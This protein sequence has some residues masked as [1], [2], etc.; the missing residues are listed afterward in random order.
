[1]IS[2]KTIN[3]IGSEDWKEII[4]RF[5]FYISDIVILFEENPEEKELIPFFL[6][7]KK[8]EKFHETPL[9]IYGTNFNADKLG[10]LLKEGLNREYIIF[11]DEIQYYVKPSEGIYFVYYDLSHK[12]IMDSF[13]TLQE[14]YFKTIVKFLPQGSDFGEFIQNSFYKFAEE[15][16]YRLQV[17]KFNFLIF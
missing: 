12:Q 6:R 4:M 2:K 3:D 11:K 10:E 7:L 9:L 13:K 8:Y 15:M 5:I 1:V 14:Q 16:E 17:I